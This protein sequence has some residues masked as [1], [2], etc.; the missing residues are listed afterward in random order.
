MDLHQII[1][2]AAA[3]VGVSLIPGPSTLIAFAH[4]AGSGWLR[5]IW[6]ALGNAS[7]SILQAMAAPAGLGVGLAGTAKR[8]LG[9]QYLGAA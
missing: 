6:T 9:V 3:V 7:A 4:G 5:S 1:L 8:L 2:F